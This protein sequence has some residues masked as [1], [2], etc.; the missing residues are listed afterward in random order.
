MA[1]SVAGTAAG[2]AG[3][4]LARTA[5]GEGA[6]GSVMDMTEDSP[7]G[8]QDTAAAVRIM[9]GACGPVKAGHAG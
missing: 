6:G 5:A 9:R 3:S 8:I 4:P 7:G 1:C 2:Q